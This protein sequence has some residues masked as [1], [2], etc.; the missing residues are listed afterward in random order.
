MASVAVLPSEL[1]QIVF[2]LAA[3]ALFYG[4]HLQL[5]LISQN[6]YD[7]VSRVAYKFI[8][9]LSRHKFFGLLQF[10]DSS[11]PFAQRI[12]SL[13]VCIPGASSHYPSRALSWASLLQKLPNLTHICVGD[14]DLSREKD[15]Q[16][17][18]QA[19]MSRPRTPGHPRK[20]K[21]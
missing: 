21:A 16:E 7:A 12:E 20:P 10:L 6:S 4:E 3:N 8:R 9:I 18:F 2:T 13:Y 19:L 14:S 5:L 17:S 1:Q 11:V 15:R